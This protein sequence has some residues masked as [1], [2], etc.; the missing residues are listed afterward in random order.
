MTHTFGKTLTPKAGEGFSLF[1]KKVSATTIVLTVVIVLAVLSNFIVDYVAEEQIFLV[2]I[3]S[4]S[5]IAVTCLLIFLIQ[6]I[7]HK[8]ADWLY[9]MLFVLLCGVIALRVYEYI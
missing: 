9:M 5:V 7:A 3:I 6:I 8:T 2:R 4:N 1:S